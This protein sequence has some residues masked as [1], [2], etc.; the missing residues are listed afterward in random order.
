MTLT[1]TARFSRSGT[2]AAVGLAALV[3]VIIVALPSIKAKREDA[4]LEVFP[5]AAGPG[6]RMI[7]RIVLN[8]GA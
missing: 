3:T 6:V 4:V 7:W 2:L 8:E 5:A 1:I